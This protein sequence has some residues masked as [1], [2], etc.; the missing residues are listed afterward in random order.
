MNSPACSASQNTRIRS[1]TICFA[2]FA[3]VNT[4]PVIHKWG[5]ATTT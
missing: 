2:N 3:I 5:V 4:L 1:S